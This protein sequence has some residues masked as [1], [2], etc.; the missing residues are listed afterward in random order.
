MKLIIACILTV[1][2]VGPVA[3]QDYLPLETGD[4]WSYI[5]DDGVKEM[6][7]VGEQVPIFQGTP[8]G[9]EH[10]IS[11]NNQGLVN[12]WTSGSDG[13]VLLWG[14]FRDGWGRLYQPPISMVDAPLAV[15][16]SWT[17][18]VD[19]YSL[20]ACSPPTESVL[21]NLSQRPSPPDATLHGVN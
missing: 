6:R 13:D 9:I 11:A 12:Y 5:A 18:T 16:N 3:G 10:T 19:I 1:T 21:P 7:I 15:G 8:Y 14:F 2:V 4:F 20:P 17:T